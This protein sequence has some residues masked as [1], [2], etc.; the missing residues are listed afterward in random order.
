MK[1]KSNIKKSALETM[2]GAIGAYEKAKLEMRTEYLDRIQTTV[3]TRATVQAR[4]KTTTDA[5][6][7]AHLGLLVDRNLQSE[8]RGGGYHLA[9]SV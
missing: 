1:H 5:T 7:L 8:V 2:S 4:E 6:T 3:V 9:V